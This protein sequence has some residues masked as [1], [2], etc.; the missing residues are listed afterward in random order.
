MPDLALQPQ[1]ITVSELNRIA[2]E[3]L[4][5]NLPLLWVAGEISNW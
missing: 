4:E 2:R 3:T 1:V 5:R